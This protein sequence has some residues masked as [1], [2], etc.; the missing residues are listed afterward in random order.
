MYNS[1]NNRKVCFFY[2]YKLTQSNIFYGFN[3]TRESATFK[4]DNWYFISKN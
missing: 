2:T 1:I 3:R 4:Y